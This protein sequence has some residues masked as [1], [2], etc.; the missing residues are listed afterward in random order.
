MK[1]YDSKDIIEVYVSALKWKKRYDD[2]NP[3]VGMGWSLNDL[4]EQVIDETYVDLTNE[5]KKQIIEKV[6]KQ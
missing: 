4:L 5:E 2:C 3:D 1:K 6:S